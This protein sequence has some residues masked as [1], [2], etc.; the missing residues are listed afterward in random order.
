MPRPTDWDALG[1][2][3]DPTPGD[4]DRIDQLARSMAELG[5]V[6]RDIDDALNTVLAKTG[7][8]AW[9]GKTADAL[10]EKIEGP[11][12]DFV[13]SIA[14]AFEG[15]SQT[16][17]LYSSAM[18]EQQARA[19][20]AL[21][22]GRGLTSED[23][24]PQRD[25]YAA[26]ARQA[27][28]A[29]ADAA[30]SAAAKVS[31]LARGIK[32]PVSDCDLFWEAFQW[33]AILLIVPALILGGPA[34]LVAIGANLTLFI[35]T[36][37]DFSQGK[38]GLLDLFLSGLGLIAPTTK[39]IPIFKLIS[40]GA[41]LTWQGLRA[42]GIGAFNFFRGMFTGGGLRDIAI[43]PG[44][45]NFT[46]LAGTWIKSGGLWVMAPLTRMPSFTAV[47]RTGGLVAIDGI[48]A[49]PG[50]IR[51]VP[52]AIARGAVAT[53]NGAGRAITTGLN[54]AGRGLTATW[55][56]TV[57]QLGGARVLRLILPVDAGEISRFGLREALRLGFVERGLMGRNVFGAPLLNAGGR[58]AAAAAPPN[59]HS[60]GSLMDLPRPDLVRL[61]L[62]DWSGM[63]ALDLN[64]GRA[65]IGLASPTDFRV[66]NAFTDGLRFAP[67]A[68]RRVDALLDTP[69]SQLNAVR[70]GDWALGA[71]TEPGLGV[72]AHL[73]ALPNEGPAFA[74]TQGLSTLQNPAGLN[75]LTTLQ[76]PANLQNVAALQ[77]STNLH[78]PA[79]LQNPT[80][81][82]GLATV[83]PPAGL[84]GAAQSSAGL[85]GLAAVEAPAGLHVP[86]GLQSTGGL[87]GLA[88]GGSVSVSSLSTTHASVPGIA[89][90][91]G[92]GTSV[93][94]ALDLLFPS[95]M[96]RADAPVFGT[97]A[98]L[99]EPSTQAR[100]AHNVTLHLDEYAPARG[101]NVPTQPTPPPAAVSQTSPPPTFTPHTGTTTTTPAVP[102]PSVSTA[103][104]P[105]VTPAVPS[106]MV[107]SHA[108]SS[109][110]GVSAT[111]PAVPHGNAGEGRA[112]SALNL[113]DG[114][115][116][117]T[118]AGAPGKARTATPPP[119][120]ATGA[121]PPPAAM[122]VSAPPPAPVHT[123]PTPQ[124]SAAAGSTPPPSV[125]STASVPPGSAGG[126]VEAP[127]SVVGGGARSG[128][129]GHTGLS[130][131][132]IQRLWAKDADAVHALFGRA[133]DP[134]R[135]A[136][137][138]AWGDL[139]RA[140][141]ERASA[142]TLVRSIDTLV[143][144]GSTPSPLHLRARQA[145]D[146]AD[147]RVARSIDRLADLG[148]DV[149]RI[150]RQLAGLSDESI[151]NRPRIDAAGNGLNDTHPAPNPTPHA[152]AGPIQHGPVPAAPTQHGPAPAG[153]SA[154]TQHGPTPAG[155]TQHGP[156]PPA[157][158]SG[159]AGAAPASSHVGP[160][161][162]APPASPP[163]LQ[164]A[165][166]AGRVVPDGQGRLV[167]AD[168]NGRPVPGHTVTDT[169][170]GLRVQNPQG[171][172]RVFDATTGHLI[173]DAVHV[174]GQ[175]G[176]SLNQWVSVR[177]NG[178]AP[179]THLVDVHGNPV[180]GHT[181]TD[182][183]SGPRVQDPQGSYRVFDATTG[184]L[185]EDA[186]H[187]R[188]QNGAHLDQWISVRHSG[189]APT[190]HLLDAHGNPVAGLTVVRRADG[191]LQITDPANG[192]F[193][194][195]TPDGNHL[196]TG[197]RLH[198]PGG[199][200]Y[201]VFT[202][203]RAVGH[204]EDAAGQVLP[205]RVVTAVNGGGVRVAYD[206]RGSARHGEF[207][208]HAA[209]GTL[210]HS[211][212]NVLKDGRRTDFQYTVDHT[213]NTWSRQ[214]HPGIQAPAG[215]NM[216]HHGHAEFSANGTDV[217][218]L[219]ST[220]NPVEVF[221]RR[222]YPGGGVLDAFRRT[223]T[224]SF[225]PTTRTT[226]WAHFDDAG[227]M[228]AHG[229]RRFDTSGFAWR[230]VDHRG[231]LVHQ[232][233]DAL[234]KGHVLAVEHGGEWRWHRFDAGGN[235]LAHGVRR[236]DLDGG[237]TDTL[238]DG[239]L[240][241]R[242]WGP[243]HLAKVA[244]HYREYGFS[245]N[246][247]RADTYKSQSKQGKDVGTRERLTD[248][249]VLT[250]TRWSEQ[251]P[252]LWVRKAMIKA[253]P[254]ESLVRHLK[255]DNRFQLYT[256]TKEGAAQT[257]GV[258]YAG[259]DGRVFDL[260]A[261]GRL[262]RFKGKLADGTELKV[263]DYATP[264]GTPPA[265]PSHLPW[266]AG[267]NRGY[268]V[269]LDNPGTGRP[270]WQDRFDDAGQV[271]VAR[272]GFADGSVRE[273]R[274]PPAVNPANGHLQGVDGPWVRLDAHGNLTGEQSLWIEQSGLVQRVSAT[275]DIDSATWKWKSLSMNGTEIASGER[276]YFRGS[277]DIR[278]P[279]DDSFRDFDATGALIRERDML[280]GG[281][282]VDSWRTVDPVTGQER[283]FVEKFAKDG[284]RVS[285]GNGEQVRRWWNPDTR[286]WGDQR[287]GDARHF[288]D[289]LR[290]PG[291]RPVVLREV[292]PHLSAQD[293]PL[294]VR[295]Y[296]PDS[297]PATPG[298]WKEFD[299]GTTVRERKALPGG[300]FLEK[301]A[302]RGQWRTYD[303]N[304]DIVAQRTDRGLVFEQV[305]GR[306]KLTGNEYD[307]RGPLT[308]L[309][310]WGRG[311]RE[312]NRMPW[313]G[314]VRLDTTL[315][316]EALDGVTGLPAP[317]G[318]R[319]SLGE[320]AY[321]SYVKVLAKKVAI[322]FGQ[323]FMLEF[324]ANLAANGIV[325]A[326]QNKPFT[327][328]D[329]LKSFAN[330][331]VG[332]TVKTALSTGMH[333]IRG[334]RWGEP[335]S[336]IS[337]LDSGKHPQRRPFNHDKTW[338]N[339]WGGNENPVRWRGGT[340]DFGFNA[341]LGAFTGWVNGSMNA[342]V[343]GVTGADG[344]THKLTGGD[345]VLDGL[346][347]GFGG[348]VTS[349]GTAVARNLFMMGA[350][351]RFFHRQGFADFW[352]QMPFKIGEK[353]VNTAFLMPEL[354]AAFNPPYLQAPPAENPPAQQ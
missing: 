144:S 222:A 140:R 251:R 47:I 105:S 308:E 320:A 20:N 32:Q 72:S 198:A 134:A 314:S 306:L 22:Q 319:V 275:G 158:G 342:A 31:A 170:N 346:V 246:G 202:G 74:G 182:T 193:V 175:N 127:P 188:G 273:Y 253:A 35:K 278:L 142:D 44:L 108:A 233:R 216:F 252:P 85:H 206:L 270:L 29:M 62:G 80:G 225:G 120:V 97:G 224:V 217:R 101:A 289:E 6:A 73:T 150:D 23:D 81:L 133:D 256:W 107:S 91:G 14:E 128:G 56:F 53:W 265:H 317:H 83:Q 249:G 25:G 209:D 268:R 118:L 149:G 132:E 247:T 65:N 329:V 96:N 229:V 143:G 8:G 77:T 248:G 301:D 102:S 19:D 210:T 139:V 45:R 79:N 260:D 155:P 84:H 129:G 110:V 238:P 296:V 34:A 126:V 52:P 5:S 180:P 172:Y 30:S 54:L 153:P 145:L 57:S 302:W 10:R 113:L 159:H 187:V 291:S 266:Q 148:V 70:V 39:A 64:V 293:G 227:A 245:P 286:A 184:H 21:S 9:M 1:L 33:L 7:D 299:H 194:R 300:G 309:R 50:V 343:W 199:D 71:R 323:E 315:Y 3:T 295:E 310:G 61:E 311:L 337:N 166:G 146:A 335:K 178:G 82:H 63:R 333:E 106:P 67:D 162:L 221:S 191:N 94:S 124:T 12:R 232:Y 262:V 276:L 2:G 307:F 37:V 285:F 179:T 201:A 220:G 279:W 90:A 281:Q 103:A 324:G 254:P 325:A 86:A 11:L 330:A 259:M 93:N 135:P 173:E 171:G 351:G 161:P 214:P 100:V 131:P 347:S 98:H 318:N 297:A 241:Q 316:R 228:T 331:A 165:G 328:Q 267:G 55:N 274:R 352:L 87:H 284:T 141:G 283:W 305:D 332:A 46:S 26:T 163:G 28:D 303:V 288:R 321:A 255:T 200:T 123:A 277:N 326:I 51:A 69:I 121:T 109:A 104:P 353:V 76:P 344:Q 115:D 261:T 322:E 60:T 112:T 312:A 257:G 345:A 336:V 116:F 292:P 15:S 58:S 59:L 204:L 88:D 167:F 181:V 226:T 186:V 4:P 183:A 234:D 258:R 17:V 212:F 16:L 230:D 211:G 205:N 203:T 36:A 190:T 174:R 114:P 24:L 219:S 348:L 92:S 41:K 157:A 250:T 130:G 287:V 218:L 263:G 196:E 269:P 49:V 298:A 152:P 27:G 290:Q 350:G 304:G 235:E 176:A 341:G 243:G 42:F 154:P 40:A 95:S 294:R 340:Y 231:N 223:D 271:R 99:S 339:E 68:V 213:A 185:I 78:V 240:A 192:N 354:R 334:A 272:E 237:W 164:L 207:Q 43:I 66:S 313:G 280:G 119:A 38:A 197:S 136:R 156:V 327:G 138:E 111:P 236:M 48:R 215:T 89:H 264:V 151:R 242:Q 349:G 122:T 168:V 125:T 195:H 137:I 160:Q 208:V 244:D 18:R 13:R 117:P 177:H 75:A 239:R 147:A 169:T 282:Y 338:A 189:G